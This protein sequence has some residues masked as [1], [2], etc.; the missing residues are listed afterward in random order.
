MLKYS[1]IKIILY[2]YIMRNNIVKEDNMIKKM[3]KNDIL[4]LLKSPVSDV[5]VYTVTDSTNTR[6]REMMLEG[7]KAP[8]LVAS[9]EQTGGRGRHGNSFFSPDSGL[10]YTLVIQPENLDLAIQK[11]TLAAA[12]SLYEAILETIGIACGIKWV[13]D[14]YLDG[15]KIAGILCEAPRS[16]NNEIMGI[17]IG[18]GINIAANEFPE[19]LKDKAGSLNR[20][21]LDRSLLTAV[22]TDRLMH[23]TAKLDSPELIEAYRSHSF[24]IG[25]DVSFV[26]NGT[27]IS[28]T[29]TDINEE[30]NLVVDAGQ[31]YV[32]SS[33]EVSLKSWKA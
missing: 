4:R 12:V 25:K 28:G 8:F 3:N 16:K 11:T 15:R 30:G 10:Y 33:G 5:T 29:V 27:E 1:Q 19:E 13:N 32:L 9:E 6:A 17:I 22:L 14:L 31:T 26:Q 20:P 23:W 24:L 7:K 2:D 21:D 18:I